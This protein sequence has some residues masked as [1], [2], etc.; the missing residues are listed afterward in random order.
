M[1]VFGPSRVSTSAEDLDA[2]SS[3]AWPRRLI[4]AQRD[5]GSHANSR[6]LAVVWPER[7]EEVAALVELA[8]EDGFSLAPLGAGSGVCGGF[9]PDPNTVVVDLKR[10]RSFELSP[11]GAEVRVGAGLLGVELEE[12]LAEHGKTVGH[13][14]SSIQCSTVGGWAATRGAGQCSGRYGKIE[15]MVTELEAVLGT[16]R[17]VRPGARAEES[18]LPLLV[19][20]EGTLGVIT[21]VGL[22]L[23]PA[24]VERAYSAFSFPSF[25]AGQSAM[26]ELYQRG[27]R[28][29][30]ARLYDPVDSLLHASGG[31]DEAL[32]ELVARTA[33]AEATLGTRSS[34]GH[35]PSRLRRGLE[36]VI[37][38]GVLKAPGQLSNLVDLL[39]RR[40]R[41]E[42]VLLLVFENVPDLQE[43]SE[44]AA[45]VCAELGARSLGEGP[46]RHWFLHRYDVSFRQSRVFRAGAFN[47][48]M[49]VA[50]PWS[51]LDG[52]YR[53]VREA[54]GRRVLLMAHV[55]HAY[56]EGAG[57]YFTFV[58]RESNADKA[59]A[60]YDAVWRDALGA[61]VA[62][63][64]C[65]SHHHG[66]GRSKAEALGLLSGGSARRLMSRAWDPAHVLSPGVLGIEQGGSAR[67]AAPRAGSEARSPWAL[68]RVSGLATV[69]ARLSLDEIA[70][71]AFKSGLALPLAG[72]VDGAL[73]LAEWLASGMPGAPSPWVDPV[74]RVLA[75]FEA[76]L[77]SG[78][79][80]TQRA[81]PRRAEGPDLAGLFVGMRGRFGHI[82]RATLALARRGVVPNVDVGV[83]PAERP[84]T[85]SER[86]ALDELG[87]VLGKG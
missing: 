67:D 15:D 53:A 10:L 61:A 63:G 21:R 78:V 34:Q 48:T 68:D 24:P 58:G 77:H 23:H 43:A 56:P 73:S 28:P 59:L 22:R 74:A 60:L 42:S 19:G 55:S 86:A 3:D 62:A 51:R 1:E 27:F 25:E 4:D 13:F 36:A 71:L 82:E 81:A 11:D 20:S 84:A 44:A 12:R 6:P 14:P 72:P 83:L 7:A 30:V 40:G 69:D 76:R 9:W 39:E 49:E 26:R 54:I 47:D 32:R 45:R 65:V 64:A 75:G 17:L 16:G 5:T 70:N 41:A 46:A 50:A 33:G 31:D 66:V 52:V 35:A 8:K 29:A 57:I 37:L 85:M 80:C 2:S 38:R 79:S 87:R 18:L